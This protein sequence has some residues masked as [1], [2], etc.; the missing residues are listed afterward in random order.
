AIEEGFVQSS[1]TSSR[2]R[3][4]QALAERDRILV[5]INQYANPDE[6]WVNELNQTAPAPNPENSDPN[7]QHRKFSS[8]KKLSALLAGGTELGDVIPLL[9]R[10]SA[11][12]VDRLHPFSGSGAFEELRLATERHPSTPKVLNLPVG[13]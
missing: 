1:I 9:F 8:I 7:Q 3:R 5:G 12:K 4:E 2:Q 10:E 6:K 13:D 11:Q